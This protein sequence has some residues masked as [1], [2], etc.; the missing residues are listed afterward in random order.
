MQQL[1]AEEDK[2]NA[3]QEFIK[4]RKKLLFEQAFKQLGKSKYLLKISK[5]SYYYTETLKNY[6]ELL[7]D[8]KKAEE[9]GKAI[10][11]KIPAFQHFIQ[12]NSMLASMFGA[13]ANSAGTVNIAGL[14]TRA[15]MQNIIQNQ[16]GTGGADA[17]GIFSEKLNQAKAKLAELK[18]KLSSSTNSAVEEFPEFKPDLQKTKTFL[19]RLEYG[20]N[21]QI[22]RNNP[23]AP[24][25]ADIALSLGYKFSDHISLGVGGGFKLGLGTIDRIR[26]KGQGASA[27]TYLDWKL[28]KQLFLSGGFEMNYLSSLPVLLQPLPAWKKSGLVGIT[29]KINI[30]TRWSKETKFQVLYDFLSQQHLPVTQ[31]LLFRVGY[32][33]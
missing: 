7:N 6:K 13:P 26:F 5:E 24:N 33:F 18:D 30:K 32:N 19:Q 11:S 17:G 28:K 29:K 21:I 10:L 31:P 4:E 22:A 12:K 3:V 27:R 20:T 15:S 2:V 8:S 16:L 23:Q 9:T 1:N 25:I 14:Q